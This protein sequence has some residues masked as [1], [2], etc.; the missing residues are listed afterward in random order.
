MPSSASPA[1]GPMEVRL[2]RDRQDARYI[3]SVSTEEILAAALALPEAEWRVLLERLAE[4]LP[5][6]EDAEFEA[7]MDRREVDFDANSVPGDVVF[8]ELHAKLS[9][10]RAAG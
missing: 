2:Q 3:R 7:E 4:S 5:E 10:M 1:V 9:K 6:E 8:A